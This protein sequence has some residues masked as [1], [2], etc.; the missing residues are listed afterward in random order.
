MLEGNTTIPMYLQLKTSLL[1]ALQSGKY[2]KGSQ[3]PP[4]PELC[5]QYGV[6]RITVRKAVSELVKDGYLFKK[7]GK[8]TFVSGHTIDRQIKYVSGFTDS[9]EQAGFKAT[10][11]LLQRKRIPAPDDVAHYFGIKPETA[12][13]YTKRKRMADGRP[14]MLE[15][16]YFP[17][18]RFSFL[19]T[20]DL[21]GSLYHLLD[22]KYGI[23]PIHPK[24][25]LLS[26][27]LAD[28]KMAKDMDVVVGTPFFKI[29]TFI[30]DQH[31][32]PVHVGHQYFLGEIYTFSI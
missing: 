8:G 13:L 28:S 5:R 12:V 1:A 26:M 29:D 2:P 22:E 31:D 21:S 6:S 25:T 14:V 7:Q 4:E 15:N 10:S 16:N 30:C 17:L 11:V 3:I 18:E 32:D 9:V 23:E 20:E 27:V 19:G 24:E